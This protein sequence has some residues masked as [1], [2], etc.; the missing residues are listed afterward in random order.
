MTPWLAFGQLL[1]HLMATP[2]PS[3]TPGRVRPLSKQEICGTRWGLDRR[4]VTARMRRE[5]ASAYGLA[6]E[7]V[8]T[9]CELDH[10]VPRS[11]GGA[12]HV[13]NLWPQPWPEARLKDRLEVR[14]D[15][16]VCAG[17][18]PLVEA[19]RMF[20]TDWRDGYRRHVLGQPQDR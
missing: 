3:L 11:M 10:L 19:Q 17:R 20:R 14:M 18:V 15:R 7:E 2:D 1:F 12:D 13:A 16:L 6:V 5:V 9:C 4:R 8:S